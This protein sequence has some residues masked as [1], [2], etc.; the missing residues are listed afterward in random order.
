[1]LARRIIACLDLRHGRVVKG[2][3]FEGLRNAGDPVGSSRCSGA[4]VLACVAGNLESV[5][6]VCASA[7][8]CETKSRSTPPASTASSAGRT[9]IRG[10]RA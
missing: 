3:N 8:L 10:A 9:S 6:A 5:S 7:A 4:Q 1:M 2:V